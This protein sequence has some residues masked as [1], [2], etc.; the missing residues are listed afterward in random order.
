MDI[1]S[2]L[3]PGAILGGSV[4][5]G[6]RSSLSISAVI[7][8][9]TSVGVDAVLGANSYLNMNLGGCCIAYGSPAKIIRQRVLGERL[10]LIINL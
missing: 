2:S 8:H 1:F 9:G 10:I 3:A 5:I 7:K 6:D 4:S